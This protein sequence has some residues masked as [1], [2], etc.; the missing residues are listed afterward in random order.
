[1]PRNGR[2][3]TTRS[4]TLRTPFQDSNGHVE[5]G[6]GRSGMRARSGKPRGLASCSIGC[7]HRVVLNPIRSAESRVQGAE[8]IAE[9]DSALAPVPAPWPRRHPVPGASAPGP[10]RPGL[11]WRAPS[12]ASMCPIPP[13]RAT[14]VPSP[15]P[16][17]RQPGPGPKPPDSAA[18]PASDSPGTTGGLRPSGLGR[19]VLPIHPHASTR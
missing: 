5:A 17:G 4:V 19:T 16:A 9:S 8:V 12:R 1:L 10:P 6:E 2:R 18:Q 15:G 11:A 14:P 3:V 13:R 7:R